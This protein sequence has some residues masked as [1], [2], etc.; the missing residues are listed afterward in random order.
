MAQSAS[1]QV[2]EKIG[3]FF[4]EIIIEFLGAALAEKENY[5]LDYKHPRPARNNDKILKGVDSEGNEHRLDIVVE[6]NGSEDV[7]G[8]PKAY[9]ETAWRRYTKHSKNKV[10]EISGAILPLVKT[11]AENMPFYAAIL[12]GEFTKNSLDQLKSEGFFVLHFTYDEIAAVYEEEGV[13][14]QWGEKTDAHALEQLSM[15]LS[16]ISPEA[17]QRM[18]NAFIS[19]YARKLERLCI[20]LKESLEITITEVRITPVHGKTKT[21]ATPKSAISYIVDY[22]EDS[23]QPIMRYEISIRYSNEQEYTMKCKTK[24][25]AIQFLTKYVVE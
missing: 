3:D 9:I 7:F 13:S 2:G 12:A 25:Q 19:K 10:Q 1:H 6:L 4:E 23:V 11:H 22:D 8:K 21:L 16:N 18:K 15:Q 5:Y 17:K 24:R 20:E 14:I